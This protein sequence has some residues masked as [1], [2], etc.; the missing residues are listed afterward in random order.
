MGDGTAHARRTS[1]RP[2]RAAGS[3]AADETPSRLAARHT[4]AGSP[5][6]SAAASTSSRRVSSGRAS[7]R[8][9]KLSSIRPDRDNTFGIPN[10][11]A[12]AA[13][14]SPRGSSSK[15]SGLPCVSAT[16]RSRTRS[17]SGQR[18]TESSSTR[19]S[20]SASPSTTSSGSPVKSALGSPRREYHQ[21]RVGHQ[22][23]RRKRQRLGR[24]SVQPLRVVHHADE[25][26]LPG[27]LGQQAEHSQTN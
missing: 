26:A 11:P 13:G 23:A 15:A 1:S 5:I 27:R 2:S 18:T 4:S 12:S 8:R 24:R 19:A 20:A 6:G 10:P 17:S 3:A 14:G 9:R 7:T 25:R 22:P 16:M 21:H